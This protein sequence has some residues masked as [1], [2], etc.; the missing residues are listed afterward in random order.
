MTFNIKQ[1][2]NKLISVYTYTLEKLYGDVID[3]FLLNTYTRSLILL[4]FKSLFYF[5]YICE[6]LSE[7]IPHL[8]LVMLSLSI[9]LSRLHV[10]GYLIIVCL[11]IV[12]LEMAF[13][14][15]SRYYRKRPTQLAK[16]FPND[17]NKRY[18]R[19]ATQVIVEAAQ[20]PIVQA[21]AVAVTGAVAWKILDVID[22]GRQLETSKQEIEA[23]GEQREKDRK[24]A[25]EE[26]ALVRENDNR[27]KGLDRDA[28]ERKTDKD[29]EVTQE[30]NRQAERTN[31]LTEVETGIMSIEEYKAKWNK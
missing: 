11:I 29:R 19:K 24:V 3:K 22:A 8:N 30:T 17:L 6:L 15:V 10:A 5:R 7:N 4:Y 25:A 23:E 28:D 27:Q 26:G 20:N 1:I 2:L 21:T 16:D 9:I 31:D 18:M 12:R 14:Y 13:F